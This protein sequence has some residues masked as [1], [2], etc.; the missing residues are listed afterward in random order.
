[1]KSEFYAIGRITKSSGLKGEVVVQPLTGFV[2]RFHRLKKIWIQTGKRR[3]K[4]FQVRTVLVQARAVRIQLEEIRSRDD[5]HGLAGKI[6]CVKRE[7]L[8]ETPEGTYFI[9]DIVGST[10][11]DERSQTVGVVKEVWKLPA[12][13]VYVIGN[14]KHEWLIP[15][16]KN[17]IRKVDTEKKQIEIQTMEGL[18]E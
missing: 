7:D 12:N 6:L 3:Y 5:A 2:Q 8:I 10:V 1:M 9:H 16:V 15:A 17:V 13:D 18:L 14:G 4:A 11:I